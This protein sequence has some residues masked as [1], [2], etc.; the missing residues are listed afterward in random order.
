MNLPRERLWRWLAPALL[1]PLVIFQL[2]YTYGESRYVVLLAWVVRRVDP[3]LLVNDWYANTPPHH[4]NAI[5]FLSWLS[6]IVPLPASSFVLHVLS[7]FGVLL[8]ADRLV[9]QLFGDRRVFYVGLFLMLR[10]GTDGLG[11]NTLWGTG[12]VPHNASVPFC[13]LAFCLALKGRLWGAALAAAMATWIHV[14]LGALTMLLVGLGM[15][16]DWRRTGLRRILASGGLYLAAVAPTLIPQWM[17]F[18]GGPALLSARQYLELHAL[19]RQP[20]H[21]IPSSWPLS[22]YYRFFLIV[23]I[24]AATGGWRKQPHRTVLM[25]TALILILCAIGTVFVEVI[26]VK[27]IIRMQLFRMTIFV[28][29]FAVLYAARFLLNTIEQRGWMEKLCALAMLAI[30][31]FILIGACAALILALRRQRRWV[32]GLGIFAVGVVAGVTLVATTSAVIPPAWRNFEVS[33]RGLWVGPLT[34]LL[35]AAIAWRYSRFL[36]AALLGLIVLVR[37]GFGLAP[38]AFREP[39]PDPWYRFCRQVRQAVPKDVVVVT[40]PQTAGFQ[41]FA[42]RAEVAN[43]KCMPMFEQG[44]VEWKRRLEDLTGGAEVRCS[45]FPGCSDAL[46]RAYAKLRED[47]FLRVAQKY[48]AQYAITARS[49]PRL[50]FPEVLRSEQYVLYRLPH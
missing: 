25:W 40:P 9:Q 48:N 39:Y 8:V 21:L 11:S 17:H 47:D 35:L 38:F 7:V 6:R 32:W 27:L 19:F 49:A 13:L 15:L 26:P 3:T 43:F 50:N 30:Q 24:A 29:F 42:E 41:L 46:A 18:M 4:H 34:L 1:T 2:G 16:P 12:I 31:N 14:Q 28:K 20:Q 36:P 37:L 33:S 5:E 22:E 10:W 23:A 45:G 44:L